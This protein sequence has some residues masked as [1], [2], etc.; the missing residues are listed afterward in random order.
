[1]CLSVKIDRDRP[2]GKMF[3]SQK[4][5]L[6]DCSR[7]RSHLVEAN[8]V[9]PESLFEVESCDFSRQSGSD[10]VGKEPDLSS[11]NKTY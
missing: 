9:E 1:V 10:C 7:T 5:K 3:L 4:H 8:A 11:T 6:N 2:N